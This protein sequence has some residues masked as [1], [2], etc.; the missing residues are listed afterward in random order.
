MGIKCCVRYGAVLRTSARGWQV[1]HRALRRLRSWGRWGAL[2]HLKWL[3]DYF[4][5][6][7]QTLNGKTFIRRVHLSGCLYHQVNEILIFSRTDSSVEVPLFL[8]QL[9]REPWPTVLL[10]KMQVLGSDFFSEGVS[11]AALGKKSNE[12]YC[13]CLF[14][15]FYHLLFMY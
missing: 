5:Q 9:E 15:L 7:K 10:K 3:G 13:F 1:Q 6:I 2:Q 14:I 11:W 12:F 8:H 4:R